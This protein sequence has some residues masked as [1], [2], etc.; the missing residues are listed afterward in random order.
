MGPIKNIAG[1]PANI[2]KAE[3]NPNLKKAENEI[4]QKKNKVGNKTSGP[5]SLEISSTAR[6]MLLMN[7]EANNPRF[8]KEL[9]DAET[10]DTAEMEAIKKRITEGFYSDSEVVDKIVDELFEMPNF[11]PKTSRFD[12]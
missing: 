7:V 1:M 11:V 3:K 10:L 6:E 4:D 9:L 2:N 5:D 12:E 8:I